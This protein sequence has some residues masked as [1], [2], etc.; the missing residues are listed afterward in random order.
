MA[1]DNKLFRP[2]AFDHYLSPDNLERLMPVT[3]PMDWLLIVVVAGLL[4]AIGIWAVTGRVPTIVAARGL[5]LRPHEV[6]QIQNRL[7]GRILSIRVR[8]GDR[9]RKGDIVA[10]I[11][12]SDIVKRIEEARR[13]G[14]MLED[15]DR[16]K[17]AAE[18]SQSALQDQQDAMEH[19]GL[20][21]LRSTLRN[22]LGDAI[23]LRPILQAHADANQRLVAEKLMGAAAREISDGESALRDNEAKIN[24]YNARL[25]LIGAQLKQI[26]TR[27]AALAKQILDESVS[28]RNEIEQVRRNVELDQFQI[29]RDSVV[30]CEY[31]GRVSE[32]MAVPG[33]VMPAGG[34]LLTIEADE[35]GTGL[36]SVSYFPVRDGKRIQPGMRVQVTPDTVERE[37]FGGIVGL[38]TSVSPIP[39][40][41]EGAASVIGN[42]ELVQSLMTGGAY[43]EVRTRLEADPKSA[44]GY[45]WSS[46]RGPDIRITPGLTHST[47]VTI[48]GRAPFNYI[49]PIFREATGVY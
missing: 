10:T 20:E 32:V 9:V 25:G 42:A 7:P 22:S 1:A 8:T 36:E 46:S 47:R 44:S 27:H 37:R 49:L 5:I 33:E 30:A 26:E 11:D 45:R 29:G 34:Q 41:R 21:A 31:S 39:V 15:Q 17:S 43:I 2:E 3:G 6:V 14:A 38:V 13:N 23:S 24:D 40:T 19:T 4:L 35:P 16:R 48:E 28:R 18:E 12:Q